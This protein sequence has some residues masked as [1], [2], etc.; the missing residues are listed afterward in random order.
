MQEQIKYK[1]KKGEE[2]RA[3]CSKLSNELKRETQWS[4]EK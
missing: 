2:N 1:N 3:K 4:R